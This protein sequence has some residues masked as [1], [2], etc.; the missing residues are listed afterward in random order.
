MTTLIPQ[1]LAHMQKLYTNMLI[2]PRGAPRVRLSLTGAHSWDDVHEM[3]QL[4]DKI[5]LTIGVKG[6][7]IPKAPSALQLSLGKQDISFGYPTPSDESACANHSNEIDAAILTICPPTIDSQ[8]PEIVAIRAAG[9]SALSRYNLGASGPRWMYGTFSAHMRVEEL[10]NLTIRDIINSS[11]SPGHLSQQIQTTLFTDTRV[12][13]MSVIA[14]AMEGLTVRRS[15]KGEKH[16]VLLPKLGGLEVREGAAAAQPHRSTY[17]RWYELDSDGTSAENSLSS[18]LNQVYTT[19]EKTHLTIYLDLELDKKYDDSELMRRYSSP[20]SILKN[21]P[22]LSTTFILSS[23]DVLST[24]PR[25]TRAS[26]SLLSSLFPSIFL[27]NSSSSASRFLLFGS[28]GTLPHLPGLQGA[29]C[30]GS[31]HLVE[32]VQFLG[33]GVMFTAMMPPLSAALADESIRTLFRK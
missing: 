17:T 27:A 19:R 29:F 24:C 5:S 11:I 2:A 13:I 20:L 23:T 1:L 25:D 16:L 18:I 3:L 12:G 15:K 33:S 8:N 21:H 14:T 28:F 22:P 31:K 6:I 10:L 4:I 30:T 32:K 7:N 9:C 26:I